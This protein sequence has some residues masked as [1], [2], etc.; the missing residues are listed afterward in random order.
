MKR[1]IVLG[2][3]ALGVAAGSMFSV[4]CAHLMHTPGPPFGNGVGNGPSK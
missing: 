4:G 2:I 3:A 1:K